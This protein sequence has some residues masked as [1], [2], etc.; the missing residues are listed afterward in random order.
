VSLLLDVIHHNVSHYDATG[1]S[2]VASQF[3]T[4]HALELSLWGY[5]NDC[6]HTSPLANINDSKNRTATAVV[7]S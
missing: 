4:Q 5:A 1:N 6:V 3:T 7:N 2:T